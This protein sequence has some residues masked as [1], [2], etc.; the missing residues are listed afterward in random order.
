MK[1][2]KIIFLILVVLFG[3]FMIVYGEKDD[4]PGAQFLGLT[5]VVVSI[6]NML[7]RKNY[8]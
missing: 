6:V 3:I 7:K 8:E 2:L 4:S 5:I 1:I